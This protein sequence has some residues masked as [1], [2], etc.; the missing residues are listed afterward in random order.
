MG[1]VLI[2][3]VVAWLLAAVTFCAVCRAAALGDDR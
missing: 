3:I 2:V 1:T